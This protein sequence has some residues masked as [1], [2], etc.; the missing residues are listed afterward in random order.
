[1]FE[2]FVF[3]FVVFNYLAGLCCGILL[4]QTAARLAESFRVPEP[5]RYRRLLTRFSWALFVLAFVIAALMLAILVQV[6]VLRLPESE[7]PIAGTVYATLNVMFLILAG[8]ALRRTIPEVGERL[9]MPEQRA[10]ARRVTSIRVLGW[11]LILFPL[12]VVIAPGAIILMLIA[13]DLVFTFAAKR[14][15]DQGL[16][17]WTLAVAVSRGL[18]LADELSS[19]VDTRSRFHTKKTSRL[20]EWLQEGVPLAQALQQVPGVVPHHAVLAAQVGVENG[21]LAEALREAA[22]KHTAGAERQGGRLSSPTLAVLYLVAVPAFIGIITSFV[23]VFII[24][25]YKEIFEGFDV[26]LPPVTV[27]VVDAAD[28]VSQYFL[29]VMPLLALPVLAMF[30]L[31][32]GYYRGWGEFDVPFFGRFLRRLDVPGILRNLAGTVSAGKPVESSLGV[33][34]RNHRRS[35]IRSALENVL[36]KCTEGDDCWYAMQESRLLARREVALLRSAQRV[37]NLPWALE[38]LAGSIERRI[39]CRWQALWEVAQPAIVILLGLLVLLFCT[40]FFLPLV[41]LLQDV[42]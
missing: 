35:F 23:M 6:T 29:L 4:V 3:A 41:Q 14:K 36:Q 13:I 37:G 25:K 15:S 22:V 7:T 38:G 33:L 32:V 39:S 27:T 24:P 30:A 18:P 1:M 5:A 20:V 8:L 17:L 9:P 28:W 2:L 12:L 21:R 19:L 11:V 10:S 16:V 31:A 42:G 34:S 26:E 40:A